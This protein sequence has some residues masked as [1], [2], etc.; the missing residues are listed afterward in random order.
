MKLIVANFKMNPATTREAVRLAKTYDQKGIIIAPPFV[1]LEAV[2]KKLRKA[3][4]CAQNVSFYES[5]PWTGE[6]SLRQLKGLGVKYVIIGHSERRKLGET[7]E[8]IA[9]KVSAALKFGLQVILCVGESRKVRQKGRQAAYKF[10][11]DQLRRDLSEISNFKFH[12]SNFKFQISNLLVAY[13]PVWAIGTGQNDDP[14][15]AAEMAGF[16]KAIL[17]S[18]CE[19]LNSKVLY[20]GS[21]TSRNAREFLTL[22]EVDG[23]LVGGESLKPA[24]F[25]KIIAAGR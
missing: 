10:I 2:S 25:Q 11:E 8:V 4:L 7:D 5:G 13:E 24:A 18:K 6:I 12:I 3:A 20:G 15:D 19:I 1:F 9:K 23:V 22:P 14:Q 17:Y 21:V 16:I